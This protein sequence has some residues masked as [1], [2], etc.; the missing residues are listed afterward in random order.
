[1]PRCL[2]TNDCLEAF[3]RL[4]QALI[5]APIIQSPDWSLP[6]EIMCDA[7]N[8]D[9]EAILGQRKD[10]KFHAIYY[11]NKTLDPAQM[12]YATIKKDAK[13]LLIWCILLL[14]EFDLKVKDKKGK[15]NVVADHLSPLIHD[16]G[17]SLEAPIDD[18]FLDECLL[19]V[20]MKSVPWYV[21]LANYLASGIIPDGYLS[22]KKK[23]FFYDVK[24]HFWEDL[25]L[26]RLCV[27]G[28][29]RRCV[30]Q[31]EVPSIISHCHDLP[32]GGHASTSNTAAKILHCGFY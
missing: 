23:K 4:K 5:S 8:Y 21:N 25:F 7:S 1:M 11:A 32:C 6:F 24:R 29:I 30:P 14:Q 16:D 28:V 12:N 2:F 27:D 19:A 18:S 26:Y 15:E 13:P 10:G 17:A 9:V 31:E 3:N 22:Q 20:G